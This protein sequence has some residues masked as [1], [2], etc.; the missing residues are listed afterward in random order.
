[1]NRFGVILTTAI[2]AAAVMI[3]GC[4]GSNHAYRSIDMEEARAMMEEEDVVIVDVRT[5]EEYDQGH[6]PGAVLVPTEDIMAG[7]VSGLPG[8]KLTTLMLYCR[9]GRRAEDCAKK[10]AELGYT[11]VCEFGG[12]MEWDGDLERQ[13]DS[14]D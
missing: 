1:M 5:R 9:T 6:I 10:L 3:G 2:M 11:N 4:S 14:S 13:D 12:I 8:D 7:D